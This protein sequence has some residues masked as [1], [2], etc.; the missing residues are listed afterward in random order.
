MVIFCTRNWLSNVASFAIITAKEVFLL[1]LLIAL[2]FVSLLFIFPQSVSAEQDI[3]EISIFFYRVCCCGDDYFDTYS[4]TIPSNL[5]IEQRAWIVFAEIFNNQCPLKMIYSPPNV[6]ILDVFFHP[7][8]ALLVLNLSSEV[9]HYGGTHFEYRLVNKLLKNAG[10]IRGVGY[11]TLLIDSVA[12]HLPEGIQIFE[13][14]VSSQ[15]T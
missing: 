15:L 6:R 3:E 5:T 14:K 7:D 1:K 10:Q 8:R 2:L 13:E 9:T 12:R 11:F 4:I